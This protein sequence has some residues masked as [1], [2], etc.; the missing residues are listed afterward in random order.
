MNGRFFSW[1]VAVILSASAVACGATPT[2][3]A[4]DASHANAIGPD[5]DPTYPDKVVSIAAASEFANAKLPDA[6]QQSANVTAS[7]AAK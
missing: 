6:P 1:A 2:G 5:P 7:S 3:H 4:T